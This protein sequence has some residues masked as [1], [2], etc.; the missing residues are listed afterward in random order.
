MDTGVFGDASEG[1]RIEVS[2]LEL[3]QIHFDGR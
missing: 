3:K 1:S 2:K